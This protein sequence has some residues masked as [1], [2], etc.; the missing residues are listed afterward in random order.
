MKNTK[1][2]RPRVYTEKDVAADPTV[3]E[4]GYLQKLVKYIPI[5]IV[6]AYTATSSAVQNKN[7]PLLLVIYYFLLA[8]T[9]LYTWFLTQEPNKP[10]PLFQTIISPIAFSAWVFALEGPFDKV[11]EHWNEPAMGT[12]VLT[13]TVLMIPVL[14]RIFLAVFT[15]GKQGSTPEPA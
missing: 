14:E 7:G 2:T 1:A 12:F 9:P 4:D 13:G 5:E 10:K 3:K 15:N 11:K 8:L 6:T